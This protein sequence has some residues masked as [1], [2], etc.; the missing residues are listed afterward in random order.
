MSRNRSLEF[1][2]ATTRGNPVAYYCDM[3]NGS[4]GPVLS[5]REIIFGIGVLALT[6]SAANGCSKGAD[7]VPAANFDSNPNA[8]DVTSFGAVGDGR[9]DD[10]DAILGALASLRPGQSLVFP[11]GKVFRHAKVLSV[12]TAGVTL[13]GPGTL[14]A[15]DEQSSALKIEAANVTVD[16]LGLAI[17]HTTQRWS[18]PDQHRLFLGPYDGIVIRDVVITGSAAA[19]LFCI[20]SS[21][22]LLERVHVSDTRADGIHMTGGSRDGRVESP[23]ITRSGDDAVAVVSYIADDTICENITV[24]SALVRTTTGGRGLSVVGGKNITYT[25]IDVADSSA[26]AVYI[27]CEGGET[28][29][30]PVEGV[31]VSGGVVTGA[32]TDDAINHGAVLV[33]SGHDTGNVID[34]QVTGLTITDTRSTASWQVGVVADFHDPLSDIS[35]DRL[36]LDA[37]PTPYKGNAAAG[38]VVLTDVVAAGRSVGAGA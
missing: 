5:R 1:P 36:T 28:T 23:T 32:N 2:D 35:F 11:K 15:V 17:E 25:G 10:T 8:R 34:V 13:L 24:T 37:T 22:F 9:A 19:G 27:A 12:S 18:T 30:Y 6:M 31:R 4:P 3:Q 20:G 14:R 26:A 33:Y 38:A 16:G 21:N 7:A 29:S